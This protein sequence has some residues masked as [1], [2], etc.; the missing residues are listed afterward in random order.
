M[1]AS[2]TL[3]NTRPTNN[4]LVIEAWGQGFMVG[5]LVVMLAVALANLKKSVLLHKLI[6]FELFI[7]IGHGTFIF[8]HPPVYGWYLSVTVVGLALSYTFHNVV[9]WIKIRPFL[10]PWGLRIYLGI[11]LL[12]Q[13]Y[14]ALEIYANF[15]YFNKQDPLFLITRPL[16]PLFR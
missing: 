8:L 6:A 9:A 13:P 2:T 1:P 16:E 15:T 12:A 14:W 4:A 5:A 10:P 11:L 7:A 3:H